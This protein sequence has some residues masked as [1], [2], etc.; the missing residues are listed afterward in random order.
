MRDSGGNE[1]STVL[2]G[3]GGACVGSGGVSERDSCRLPGF[4]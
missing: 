4:I 2:R 3:G 1:G